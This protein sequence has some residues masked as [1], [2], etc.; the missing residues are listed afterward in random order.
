MKNP[1]EGFYKTLDE[2]EKWISELED[3]IMELAYTEQ[4]KEKEFEKVMMS[5][6]PVGQLEV[7]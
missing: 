4:Q 6:G 2:A 3:K 1:L 5:S 7:E